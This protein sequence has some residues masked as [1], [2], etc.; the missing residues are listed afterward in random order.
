MNE[1]EIYNKIEID[2]KR[3]KEI[4]VVSVIET[5]GSSPR[6]VGSTMVVSEDH[7]VFG[8]VSG[9]CIESFVYSKALE[10]I[11]NNKV[12]TLEFGVTNKQAWEVGLTCGGKIK[13]FIEKLSQDNLNYVKRINN[14]FNTNNSLTVAT[15]LLDGTKEILNDNSLIKNKYI[16]SISEKNI[17][18]KK[19]ELKLINNQYWF[20]KVFKSEIKLIIIGSVHIAEP[21]IKFANVLGYRIVLIDPRSNI[22]NISVN[23]DV[24]VI[25]D[26]PDEALKEITIDDNS[27][28]VTLTHDTKLDDPALEYSVKSKAFYIGCLGS[29]K[30]H[31][32]RIERLSKK[33]IKKELLSK[34]HGPIGLSIGA[35]TPAEIASSIISQIIEIKNSIHA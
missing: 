2:L 19:S 6:P 33:G 14:T 10:V 23:S 16:K 35:E 7:K 5:W 30:T 25:K 32:S 26:W 13:V 24:K 34:L 20:F 28:V 29:K 17:N 22:K 18:F 9:G 8:S 4:A 11:K 15:K 27:A 12:I 21:L 31:A 3:K 1:K